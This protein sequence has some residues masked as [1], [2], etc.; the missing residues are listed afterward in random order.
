MCINLC[1]RESF[2]FDAAQLVTNHHWSCWKQNDFSIW[3]HLYCPLLHRLCLPSLH[4]LVSSH[5]SEQTPPTTHQVTDDCIVVISQPHSQNLL[6]A[7]LKTQFMYKSCAP[8]YGPFL[9][10]PW[11]INLCSRQ[12]RHNFFNHIWIMPWITHVYQFKRTLCQESH[13]MVWRY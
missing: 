3:P 9:C 4:W 7:Q 13:Q 8:T 2:I 11:E 1:S 10:A 12:W 6:T 5:K